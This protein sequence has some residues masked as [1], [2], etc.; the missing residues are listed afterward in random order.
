MVGFLA[1]T[2]GLFAVCVH[3]DDSCVHRNPVV[4]AQCG[5]RH[6]CELVCRILLAPPF[7][8]F[9][10]FD[11]SSCFELITSLVLID[12]SWVCFRFH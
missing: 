5:S 1:K 2:F 6:E 12:G 9:L 3:F 7:A 10:S 8:M 11:C 4:Y